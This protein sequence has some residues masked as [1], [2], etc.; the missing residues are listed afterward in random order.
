MPTVYARTVRR[1]AEIVGGIEALSAQLGVHPGI[2]EGWMAGTNPV[3]QDIFFRAVDIVVADDVNQISGRHP[4][5]NR[6][7]SKRPS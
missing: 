1:A 3:P 5:V 4:V 6:S 7:G 2:L